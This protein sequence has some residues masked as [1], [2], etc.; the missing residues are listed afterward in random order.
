[1][2]FRRHAVRQA[3]FQLAI[4]SPMAVR[5]E[6]NK[7]VKL[8]PLAYQLILKWDAVRPNE[9]T[10]F[11][12]LRTSASALALPEGPGVFVAVG[13]LRETAAQTQAR[14]SPTA[15]PACQVRS[16]AACGPRHSSGRQAGVPVAR[17]SAPGAEAQ[18]ARCPWPQHTAGGCSDRLHAVL[19]RGTTRLS[20]EARFT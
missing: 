20:D 5:A 11:T 13:G 19:R 14:F 15:A 4:P 7:R 3:E 16:A 8:V 18:R 1:M 6:H 17:P 9:T 2:A 12:D 10:D